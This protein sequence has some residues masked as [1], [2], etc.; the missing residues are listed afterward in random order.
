MVCFADNVIF[1]C[2]RVCWYL[3]KQIL[4]QMWLP[5]NRNVFR[6]KKTKKEKEEKKKWEQFLENG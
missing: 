4:C 5:F 6:L 1:H 2:Y 3:Q